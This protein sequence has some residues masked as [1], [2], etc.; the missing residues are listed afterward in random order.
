MQKLHSYFLTDDIKMLYYNAYIVST[1]GTTLQTGYRKIYN[2]QNR[3]LRV[4]LKQ[5]VTK[6]V[7]KLTIETPWPYWFLKVN[8]I[9]HQN[10]YLNF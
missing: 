6:S 5:H 4:I 10:I 1:M 8:I 9:W 3:A 7:F 2:I